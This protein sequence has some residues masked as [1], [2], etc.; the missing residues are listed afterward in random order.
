MRPDE[1][2]YQTR[3]SNTEGELENGR[4]D[5]QSLGEYTSACEQKE[6][7]WDWE[8]NQWRVLENYIWLGIVSMFP[9]A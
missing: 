6:I 3:G 4:G 5:L 2:E 8:N 9:A 7:P 1:A